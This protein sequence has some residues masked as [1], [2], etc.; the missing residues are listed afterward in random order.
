MANKKVKKRDIQLTVIRD[1]GRIAKLGRV[2]NFVNLAGFLILLSGMLVTF[3]AGQNQIL[4]AYPI[5]SFIA[6]WLL[7]QWGLHLTHHYLRKP[8]PDQQL[9]VGVK[10]GRFAG[11]L[12]H[13]LLPA[14]HLLLTEWG[15]TVLHPQYQS[16]KIEAQ[17]ETWKQTGIGFRRYFGR[18]GLGNPSKEVTRQVK[19]LTAYLAKQLPDLPLDQVP[20]E[21]V[22]VFTHADKKQLDVARS[23][24]PAMHYTAVGS[25]LEKGKSKGK[26][27][28]ERYAILQAAFDKMGET[29]VK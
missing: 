24:I 25:Y 2:A 1:E 12:Y 4:L 9:D 11:R 14:S 6:G 10:K 18:E 7:L 27:A 19:K 26:M 5:F 8:R 29:R 20:I 23:T 3:F 28:A 16:G 21:S 13:F 17:G 22:I 15:L